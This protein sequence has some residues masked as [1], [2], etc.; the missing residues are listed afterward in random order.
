MGGCLALG[1]EEQEKKVA[2]DG[3]R[4]GAREGSG[5]WLL[6]VAFALLLGWAPGKEGGSEG[7]RER[8]KCLG[9]WVGRP[10]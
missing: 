10:N 5:V 6:C 2:M 9:G 1:Y 4:K 3:R 7:A 8:G